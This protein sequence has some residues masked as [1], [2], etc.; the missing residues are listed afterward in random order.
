[1]NPHT[2]R[3]AGRDFIKCLIDL[4]CKRERIHGGLLANADDDGA[5]AIQRAFAALE[6][7]TDP[8]L[9]DIA[10]QHGH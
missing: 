6:R 7:L 2:G 10:N 3:Q 4:A 5:L 8:N 9:P 1:M